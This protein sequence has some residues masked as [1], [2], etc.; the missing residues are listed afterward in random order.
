MN[1]ELGSR[2]RPFVCPPVSVKKLL[3]RFR[4]N[5]YSYNAVT[6]R[7]TTGTVLGHPKAEISGSNPAVF[8][9]VLL[10]KWPFDLLTLLFAKTQQP[11]W[12]VQTNFPEHLS[13]TTS[14]V[15]SGN[16][17]DLKSSIFWD[18]T[19]CGPLKVN[20]RFEVIGHLYFQDWRISQAR[21]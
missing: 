6:S 21:N 19:P 15:P 7:S 13:G 14:A 12:S 10:K 18:T 8:Y 11:N 20:R 9:V 1:S 16:T 17:S 3:N 4:Q 5:K 2:V